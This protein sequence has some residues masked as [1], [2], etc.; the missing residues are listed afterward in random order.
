MRLIPPYTNAITDSWHK[1][2][3]NTQVENGILVP[4]PVKP[5]AGGELGQGYQVALTDLGLRRLTPLECERLMG[6]PD[7][8]THFTADG[9]EVFDIH[10]Y[11]MCGNGVVAPVA[12]W[13]AERIRAAYA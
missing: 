10:R 9:T 8:H 7:N 2:I 3:G 13:V 11:R 5:M 4:A 1:G 6:W 12:Q